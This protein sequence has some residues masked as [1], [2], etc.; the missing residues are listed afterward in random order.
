M[1]GTETQDKRPGFWRRFAVLYGIG[2]I[3]TLGLLPIVV[4]AARQQLEATP[5]LGIPFPAFVALS[6]LNP[7]IILAI[8]VAMGIR[9]APQ[10]GLRSYIDERVVTGTPILP[11][12]RSDLPLAF[13]LGGI[14]GTALI[15]L[16]VAFWN[17]LGPELE[18]LGAEQRRTLGLTLAGVLYGGIAEELMMRW[19]MMSFLAWAAWRL[20]SRGESPPGTGVM[21]G[22]VIGAAIAFGL[23]HLPAV[24]A[25]AP[26]TTPLILRTVSLNA[27]G[28]LIFGWLFWRRSL[29]A[30]MASHASFHVVFSLISW[31]AQGPS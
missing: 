23:A 29:E 4:P 16:D 6:L 9:L 21:W 13:L 11:K 3:S 5:E 14:G 30:A 8:T 10:L 17:L 19:G 26:L 31:V 22:A 12:L 24:A 15:L 20:V 25:A 1:S 18:Q 28:G 27:I 7:L 2:A